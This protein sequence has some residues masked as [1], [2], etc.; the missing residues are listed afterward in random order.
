MT[1]LAT[2][3]L[4]SAALRCGT[5]LSVCF[6]LGACGKGGSGKSGDTA[7]ARADSG[8]TGA[9]P[10]IAIIRAA[11]WVGS[12]WSED[13]IRVGLQEENM[14]ENKD[15]TF[16]TSS[17]QG[18]LATLPGLLDNAVDSKVAVIVTLQDPTLKAAVQ[19]VKTTP[20]VF[21]V[22]SDPFAAGAGTSDSSHLPN[23]TG[24]YSPG[25]GDP[26]QSGRVKLIKDLVP[27][28]HRVGVL[29]S[30][31]EPLAVQF[32]DKLT[33]AGQKAGLTVIAVPVP[34][35]NDG[36]DAANA[37][38]GKK[39]DAIEVFG[40][41]AHAAFPAIIAVANAHKVPVFSSSP[42][43]MAKGAI[44][45]LYPDFAEGGIEA[46]H[47]I[48]KII[49][50]TNPATIPFFKETKTKTSISDANAKSANVMVP[51]GAMQKADS[52]AHPKQ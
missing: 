23:V 46:G 12:E 2:L 31:D 27:K 14:Q 3:K 22:L 8:S 30:P 7:T 43:E 18:D 52:A 50:G 36:T 13:A 39:V 49:H 48:G 24:V 41:T 11:D 28:A 1:R 29:F 44:A 32:K 38:V 9:R 42:F 51:A 17:A 26:E 35:V 16:K 34:T 20:I 4:S 15:Y 37:I 45:A 6:V 25:F 47:M 10:V 40:N 33:A 19:R 5:A 21:H